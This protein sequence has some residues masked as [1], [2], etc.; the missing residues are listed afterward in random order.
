M[1]ELVRHAG[2][3]DSL[4]PFLAK[5]GRE[6]DPA[7]APPQPLPLLG[8]HDYE[9]VPTVFGNDDRLMPGLVA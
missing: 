3:P 1:G 4:G 9:G 6:A 5:F 2:V 8:S 7:V